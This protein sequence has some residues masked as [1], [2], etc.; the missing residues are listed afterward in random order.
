[1]RFCVLAVSLYSACA[2]HRGSLIY[3]DDSSAYVDGR[4]PAHN[5][6][7]DSDDESSAIYRPESNVVDSDDSYSVQRPSLRRRSSISSHAQIT[8]PA[9]GFQE[10]KS[11]DWT[12]SVD[13]D[14][15]ADYVNKEG[16]RRRRMDKQWE[17]IFG[18]K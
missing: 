4:R 14:E 10:L 7:K 5:Q 17:K 1:M 16:H 6:N 8:I 11:E 12:H 2:M 9:G 3:G 15:D 13:S 18:D